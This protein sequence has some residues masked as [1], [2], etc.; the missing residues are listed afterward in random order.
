MIVGLWQIPKINV[1]RRSTSWTRRTGRR[2]I[3]AKN[4]KLE[5]AR[6]TEPARE[7]AMGA[8]LDHLDQVSV[9][10]RSAVALFL[11]LGANWAFTLIHILQEWK[12]EDVPL[13]RVFGAVVGVWIPNWLGFLLFTLSLTAIQWAVGLAAIAGWLPFHGMVSLPVAVGALGALVGARVADNVI[14]HWGLYGLGYRPNPGL[15][16]TV[17]YSVEAIF[18]LATFW[19]GL[20]LAACPAWIGFA[21]GAG[22]FVAVLPLLRVLRAVP[23]WRRDPWVRWQPLPAWTKD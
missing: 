22:F 21:C 12:G 14:S 3:V 2:I 23:S 4:K 9:F 6:R 20:S 19:K 17:L 16:S 18:I 7:A 13:W 15:S 5:G 11:I 1:G 10:G 8:M